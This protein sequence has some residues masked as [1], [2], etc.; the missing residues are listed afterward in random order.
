MNGGSFK[1]SIESAQTVDRQKEVSLPP[2]NNNV[3]EILKYVTWDREVYPIQPGIPKSHSPDQLPRSSP[4]TLYCK[5][6]SIGSQVRI[7][8]FVII[9]K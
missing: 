6:V 7:V 3:T 4:N 8:T 5:L 2:G 9:K 1:A